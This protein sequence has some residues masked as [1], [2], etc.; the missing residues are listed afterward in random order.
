MLVNYRRFIPPNHYAQFRPA[1]VPPISIS[2]SWVGLESFVNPGP[3]TS[4]ARQ[5]EKEVKRNLAAK[6][7]HTLIFML[8]LT[9][10]DCLSLAYLPGKD[11]HLSINA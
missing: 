8:P 10:R 5:L 9:Q 4:P 7:S 2:G 6:L 3:H 1:K 11:W